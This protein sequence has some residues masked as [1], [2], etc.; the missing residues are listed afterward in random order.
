MTSNDPH[1]ILTEAAQ[2]VG[3]RANEYEGDYYA[4]AALWS[5]ML[6]LQLD[7]LDVIRMMI[8]LKLARTINNPGHSDSWLD[9]AGY[10]SLGPKV[11]EESYTDVEPEEQQLFDTDWVEEIPTLNVTSEDGVTVSTSSSQP[12][13]DADVSTPAPRRK[14]LVAPDE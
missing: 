10:A 12:P 5:S 7:G 11:F 4:T 2:I 3:E 1:K 9:I 8:L 13:E 6:G 14:K